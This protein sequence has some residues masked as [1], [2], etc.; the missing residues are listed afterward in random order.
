MSLNLVNERTEN[1]DRYL[2]IYEYLDKYIDIA[3]L[4]NVLEY[5]IVLPT[6]IITPFHRQ[7]GRDYILP[8]VAINQHSKMLFR[9]SIAFRLLISTGR[10]HVAAIL[11]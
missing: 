1:I 11:L 6:Y 2:V 7:V 9:F 8:L 4:D 10:N 5:I 3:N